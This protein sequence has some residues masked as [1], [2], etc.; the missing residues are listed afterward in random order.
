MNVQ[1]MAAATV[2][3]GVSSADTD[4]AESDGLSIAKKSGDTLVC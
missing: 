3:A 1:V 4:Q 2:N